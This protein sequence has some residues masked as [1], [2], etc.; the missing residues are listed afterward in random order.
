M[1]TW[2]KGAIIGGIW[3]LLSIIPYSYM[4]TFNNPLSKILLTIIGLPVFLSLIMNLHFL[5][6]FIASPIIGII[7]GAGMGYIIE[8]IKEG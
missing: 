2:K 3:G 1:K 4:S 8:S 6:V 5:Y 7:I